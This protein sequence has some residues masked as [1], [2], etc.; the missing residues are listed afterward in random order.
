MLLKISPDV[1]SQQLDAIIQL[2]IE[3]KIDG[4]IATNTSISRD[5]LVSKHKEEKGEG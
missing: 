3:L 1:N 5:G 2:V 4:V